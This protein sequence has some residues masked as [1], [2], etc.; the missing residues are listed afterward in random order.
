MKVKLCNKVSA[1]VLKVEKYMFPPVE[2]SSGM[3]KRTRSVA[4]KEA[5]ELPEPVPAKRPLTAKITPI[6][7]SQTSNDYEVSDDDDD[8]DDEEKVDEPD[9]DDRTKRQKIRQYE[10]KAFEKDFSKQTRMS[11]DNALLDV[12]RNIVASFVSIKHVWDVDNNSL[13]IRFQ[14]SKDPPPSCFSSQ[15]QEQWADLPVSAIATPVSAIATPVIIA[16]AP[17]IDM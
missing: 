7:V 8:D 10:K 12:P 6:V 4:K 13:I 16:S 9:D 15:T 3:G 2:V 14:T 17:T 5:I 1:Y 11:L